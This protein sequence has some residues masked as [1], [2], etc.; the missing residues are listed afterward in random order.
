MLQLG[1]IIDVDSIF[2]GKAGT[3]TLVLEKLAKKASAMSAMS[4][5]L[6]SNGSVADIK[7]DMKS[8]A[9]VSCQPHVSPNVSHETLMQQE[10]QLSADMKVS[11]L[12]LKKQQILAIPA[13]NMSI[14]SML[15]IGL[16]LPIHTIGAVAIWERLRRSRE[17]FTRS[18]GRAIASVIATPLMSW[19][20][21][22]DGR[23]WITV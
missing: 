14:D 18:N 19:R 15:A 12:T 7:A 3:R 22:D 8:E 21:S 13:N 10:I 5:S 20:R 23:C 16:R 2:V 11:W 17:I 9:E 6:P 1:E 4:E